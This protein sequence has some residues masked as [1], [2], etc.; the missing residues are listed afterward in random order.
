MCDFCNESLDS[1]EHRY[2]Y[3][4]VTQCFWTDV[5]NWLKCKYKTEHILND[6]KLIVTN[7]CQ[8]ASIV[9]IVMLNAKYYIFSCFLNKSEPSIKAFK[10]IIDKAESTERFI[11]TNKNLLHIHKN[12]W[13]TND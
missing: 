6:T 2:F 8:G 1:I 5:Q 13:N 9:E 7:M 11:A 3:C 12:R 4:K 10:C